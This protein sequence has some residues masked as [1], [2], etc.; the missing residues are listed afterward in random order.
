MAPGAVMLG[1]AASSKNEGLTLVVAAAAGLLVAKRWRDVVRLWPAAVIPLP[2]LVLRRVH[3]LQTDLTEGSVVAR[4]VE[5][6]TNP[7]PLLLAF[8]TYSVGQP[9]FWLALALGIAL[10]IR[11]LLAR[12]RFVLV[13]V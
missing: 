4:I 11:P 3:H 6:V 10:T 8:P 5:P 7:R 2:W 9:F 13:A 12:E 1:L